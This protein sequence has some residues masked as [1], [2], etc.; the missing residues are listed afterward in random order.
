MKARPPGKTQDTSNSWNEH[1]SIN[2]MNAEEQLDHSEWII[3]SMDKISKFKFLMLL[4]SALLLL[5]LSHHSISPEIQNTKSN[6][7][8]IFNRS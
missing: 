7:S 6:C 2:T 3:A 8:I 4:Q 1:P 5:F